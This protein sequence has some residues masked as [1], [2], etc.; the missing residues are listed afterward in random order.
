MA[1]LYELLLDTLHDADS[2]PFVSTRGAPWYRSD[3]RQ[4]YWRPAWDG[5]SPDDPEAEDHVP[6]ILIDF[7]FHE[8]RHTHS[9]WL[10]QDGIPEVARRP[11][12]GHKMPG[13]AKIYEHGTPEME[14]QISDALEARWVHL[15]RQA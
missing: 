2:F 13:I 8:G 14:R 6:V 9:T 7:T 3:L 4:R 12:L 1:K 15:R 11:Q 10:V 5:V